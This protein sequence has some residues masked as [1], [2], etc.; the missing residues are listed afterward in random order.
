MDKYPHTISSESSRAKN[1]GQVS[2]RVAPI[3]RRSGIFKFLLSLSQK[4]ETYL[5]LDFQTFKNHKCKFVRPI[6]KKSQEKFENFW[7]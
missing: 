1:S 5:K 4:K 3:C 6:E 2:E 7:Q